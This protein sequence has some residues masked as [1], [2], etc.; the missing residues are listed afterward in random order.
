MAYPAP[1]RDD[2]DDRPSFFRPWWRP[3]VYAVVPAVFLWIVARLPAE[4]LVW[5]LHDV[6]APAWVNSAGDTVFVVG[7]VT[8]GVLLWMEGHRPPPEPRPRRT[9]RPPARPMP[10]APPAPPLKP[11]EPTEALRELNQQLNPQRNPPKP[12]AP[13]RSGRHRLPWWT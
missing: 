1:P 10:P 7:W 3:G 11:L 6:K 2:H 5:A 4:L 13:A 12:K 8:S 9:I